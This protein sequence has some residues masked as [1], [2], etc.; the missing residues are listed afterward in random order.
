[1]T[2]NEVFKVNGPTDPS[3]RPLWTP[4]VVTIARNDISQIEKNTQLFLRITIHTVVLRRMLLNSYIS[5]ICYM[6]FFFLVVI[7]GT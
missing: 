1:M 4:T 6:T 5:T 2:D 3:L 7:N